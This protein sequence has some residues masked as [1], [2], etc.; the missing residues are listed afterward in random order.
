MKLTVLGCSGGIGGE[1]L[2]TTALL[3]DHDV[4]IDAGTG[5]ADLEMAD[6][7]RIVTSMAAASKAAGVPDEA[8]KKAQAHH[9][10]AHIYW[11]W[12]TAENSDGFHNPGAARET[13][14]RS[15]N[16]SQAGIKLLTDAMQAVVA[17][18]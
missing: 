13:L 12:W 8:I 9:D 3:V 7:A 2:R 17:K 14:T 15:V 4:L 5:V 18:K 10:Q 16:E 11:E 6:L 1:Q